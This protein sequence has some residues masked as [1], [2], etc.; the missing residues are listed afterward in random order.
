LSSNALLK[1]IKRKRKNSGKFTF[2]NLGG[3]GEDKEGEA[4]SGTGVMQA[5]RKSM[6]VKPRGGCTRK[7]DGLSIPKTGC[8]SGKIKQSSP[9]PPQGTRGLYTRDC[10]Y[11]H[12]KK[13]N[14]PE[15]SRGGISQLENP[16]PQTKNARRPSA[17][18]DPTED[19]YG[20][21]ASGEEK[22]VI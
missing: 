5:V 1:L 10:Q 19:A 3:K 2:A 16:G 8:T 6:T 11:H 9:V 21:K 15:L 22:K 4:L 18:G 20:R 13:S 12:L 14:N 7:N 17:G